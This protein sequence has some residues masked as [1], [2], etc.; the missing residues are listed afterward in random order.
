MCGIAGWAGLSGRQN[1]RAELQRMCDVIRHRGPDD[2]GFH[3]ATDVALGMRRLSII[4]VAGGHQPISSEDG[5][6]TIV[7]NGEIYNFQGLRRELEARGHTFRTHTDTEVILHRFEERGPQVVDDLNGMFALAIWD[8]RAQQLF[9][10]R[11][12]MGIKPL[13]YWPVDGGVVFASELKSI[14]CLPFFDQPIDPEGLAQYLSLGYVPD[15]LSIYAGVHKLPP[16]H[17]LLWSRSEGLRVEQYWSPLRA[18]DPTIDRDAAVEEIRRLIDDAV[19]ARLV[20]DVPLGAFLSGGIDSST[21]VAHMARHKTGA[22]KTF[23]IGFEER[24]FN[25]ADDARAVAEALGTQHTQ[26]TVRPDV[27]ALIEAVVLGFDEPFAD[28]SAIPTYLVSELA[29]QQVTVSLSGDGGDE[30]FGGYTRYIET[31]GRRRELP[32][33]LGRPLA[34]LARRLPHATLGRNRLLDLGRRIEGR[35]ATQVAYPLDP[36]EGGVAGPDLLARLP[37]FERCLEPWFAQVPTGTLAHRLMS[38]DLLTYL[39]GDILTKVDRMS[40]AVSLEARVP[41]LDHRLVEFAMRIPSEL[42]VRGEGKWILREAVRHLLPERVFRKAKQGFAVPLKPWLRNELRHRLE[43]LTRPNA[44]IQ[45]WVDRASVLRLRR[46]HDERRRDHST[47][48][49]RLLV[50]QL[51]LESRH[52]PLPTPDPSLLGAADA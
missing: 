24:E 8:E 32:T 36:R 26:L 35:Y 28:S 50:L 45:E 51:W 13:Y 1:G 10:A 20:A 41:L 43:P 2:E 7:Y 46:E 6:A 38:V 9:V 33:L 5:N 22:L 18:E 30:L 44:E 19:R 47:L 17:R 31:L 34:A 29:R 4:D 3:L 48:L 40:M 25:E 15:P 11:D 42:K 14:A 21:V 27:D 52:S 37:D 12:R 49:W 16:G 39:P 23:S